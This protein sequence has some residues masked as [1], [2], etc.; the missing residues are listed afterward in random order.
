MIT[1]KLRK[2]INKCIVRI[3]AE[4]IKININ[5]PYQLNTPLK[6]QGTGFFINDKGY[7]LT[8]SHVVENSKNIYI[9][10][11]SINTKKY[12]CSI[13][14][15]IPKFDLAIIKIN[16]KIKTSYV[17]LGDSNKLN[18]GDSVFAVGFPKNLTANVN[19]IKYTLGIV[20]GQ[21]NGLIQ[22]DTAINPGNSG[23]P[24]FLKDKVV[25]I[26]SRKLVGNNVSNIGYCI[27]INYYKLIK[28]EKE[29]I[30][31][32]PMLNSNF[33]ITDPK[34]IKNITSE[35][36]DGI[37]ISKIYEGSILKSLEK[38]E[39]ILLTKFDKY[40]IDNN[41]YSDYRWL[42]EKL[43]INDLINNYKNN[44]KINIEYYIKNIKYKKNIKLSKYEPKIKKIYFLD[45]IDYIIVCGSIFMN[46]T[47]DH[48]IE[49]NEILYQL[50]NDSDLFKS[51]VICTFVFPNS[52]SDIYGNITKNELISRVNNI[53]VN[54][55]DDFKKSL[56]KNLVINKKKFIKIESKSYN[57]NL[58]EKNEIENHNSELSKIYKFNINNKNK[59][60]II[61]K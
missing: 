20:S 22:T 7:I 41:G 38:K 10:I 52:I 17:K 23:G 27:P 15:I 35:N 46:L 34:T 58:F 36:N 55:L 14:S 32:T 11:P 8:C 39:D 5:I 42:G 45:S 21:Q 6:G 25:G 51:H 37:I 29:K 57:I 13:I 18:V 43:N 30:I 40:I 54:N 61:N 44:E 49:N 3:S 47:K 26:N 24:L 33:N 28:N 4:S 60:N 9:E 31:Y 48:L 50:N 16:S 56:N 1:N 2:E 53:E 59:K 19:N 12:L